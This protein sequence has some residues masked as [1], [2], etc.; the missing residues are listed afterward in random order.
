MYI[1]T[2][3][4]NFDKMLLMRYILSALLL[5]ACKSE[6]P[7][8]TNPDKNDDGRIIVG[9]ESVEDYIEDIAFKNVA[10]VVNQSSHV[11]K[12]HLVDVLLSMGVTV[13]KIFAPEHGFRGKADA[14]EKINDGKD[15]KTG[16]DIISL[17]G[18][19]KKP[20]AQDLKGVD[21]ILFDIQDVGVRFY[22]YLSTL[23]YIMEAAAENNIKVIVLDRPNPNAHYVDGP[24]LEPSFSSYVGLHPV[25]VVYGMT[26]GEYAQMINGEKWLKDGVKCD[27]KVIPCKNYNHNMSYVLPIKP[28]PNLP[29]AMAVGH[30]PSLCF[31]EGTTLSVGRGTAFPFQ[32]IGHPQ[33]M[34]VTFK[35]EPKPTEGAKHP[36]HQFETCY[37]LDLRNKL[38]RKDK[39]DLTYLLYFYDMSKEFDFEFFNKDVFFDLLAGTDKLKKMILAGKSESEIRE[40]WQAGLDHFKSVRDKYLIYSEEM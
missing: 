37:G 4:S 40:S 8:V 38:P 39:L 3:F 34:D 31:F 36:K 22:T 21:I 16:L 11:S 5:L 29:N 15:S 35:F 9:A 14:G 30:Y 20:S 2:Q 33:A 17:Y 12:K 32:A 27:L 19:K 26:I 7:Q 13:S 24:V 1:I 6:L 25:P 28:S 10:M 18:K 23:H